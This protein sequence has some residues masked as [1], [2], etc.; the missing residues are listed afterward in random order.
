M[1]F[2]SKPAP[3]ASCLSRGEKSGLAA[4]MKSDTVRSDAVEAEQRIRKNFHRGNQET[5][6][7][8]T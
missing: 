8:V 4:G 6:A 3:V 1:S 5:A 2:R 7:S